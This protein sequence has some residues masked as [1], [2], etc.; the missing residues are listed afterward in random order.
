GGGGGRGGGAGAVAGIGDL[1][2]TGGGK[3]NVGAKVDARVEGRVK[4][5]APEV[6]SSNVDR[7]ALARYVKARLKAIQSCYEKELKRNPSLKGKVMV[8]FTIT[9]IG[10]T[11][12]IDIQHNT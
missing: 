5:A 9:K 7:D 8:R 4:D 2:T 6:E 12:H 3:V 11:G 10:R 1:G